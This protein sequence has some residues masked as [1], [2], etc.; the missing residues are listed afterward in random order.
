LEL[1]GQTLGDFHI[2]ALLGKGS[3]ARVY[4]ARQISLRRHVALKVLEEGIF[5]PGNNVKRFL[6]EAEALARLEHGNIVPV[7]SAGEQEPYYFFA[8]RL[9][10]GGTLDQAMRNGVKL[11]TAMEWAVDICRGLAFAHAHGIVHRD[12]KPTNVLIHDGMALLSDFG[13]ARL[14]DASTV[15][16]LGHLLGTPLYMS[17]EQTLGENAGPAADCF[18][19]GIILYQLVTGHHPF[20]HDAKKNLSRKE[21]RT[22]LFQRIQDCEFA[23]PSKVDPAISP[24]LE[25]V[26]LR[27]LA[28]KPL[29]RFRDATEMLDALEYAAQKDPPTQRIVR[30]ARVSSPET[31]A[32]DKAQDLNTD[33]STVGMQ[34]KAEAAAEGVN[35]EPPGRKLSPTVLAPRAQPGESSRLTPPR[36]KAPV[37]VGRYR[38]IRELGHGGQGV[39]YEAHDPI[40]DRK[41]ALKV[42][43]QDAVTDPRLVEL[44]WHEARIAARL[45]H[46]NIITIYD[47]GIENKL[48]YLTMQLIDGL[49]LDRLLEKRR[50]L[51]P[52]FAIQTLIQCADALGFAHKAEIIH[53]DVKPGNILLQTTLRSRPLSGSSA[54]RSS[55]DA[56]GAPHALL[57]DFT[58]SRMRQALT[59]REKNNAVLNPMAGTIAYSSPEQFS[60]DPQA[61]GPHSDIFALGI[62]FHE[63]L[64]GRQLFGSDDPAISRE[65]IL[66]EDVPPPS[67]ILPGLGKDIDALCLRMLGRSLRERIHSCSE[68]IERAEAIEH[69][70]LA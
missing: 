33:V 39:V 62:V 43:R 58:M 56:L 66:H 15:T 52:L 57:T 4:Q 16:Q 21:R 29:N 35:R 28:R 25:K 49:S 14:R 48:E 7:Y 46:P 45:S 63:M 41:V 54:R 1:V 55:A 10:R 70:L 18:A 61:I 12:L 26:L 2:E 64:T 38:I 32:P 65:R 51:P 60:G 34:A 44:F 36:G 23:P 13:L 68:V 67:S 30:C 5:T 19:L 17:P 47:F 50:R 9:I 27:A 31:P 6:R 53:L 8:M 40:L 59:E 11:S 24:S 20:L 22:R 42:L 37:F 69:K 3:M